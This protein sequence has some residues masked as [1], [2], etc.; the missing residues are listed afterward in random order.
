MSILNLGLYGVAMERP[1][2]KE[3]QYPGMEHLFVSC[4]STGDIRAA[5][6]RFP[7]L[8]HGLDNALQPL[9][10]ML[11]ERFEQLDLKG[12][13]FQRGHKATRTEADAFFNEIKVTPMQ[14]QP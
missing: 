2:I 11:Y 12:I 9:Y 3:D 14:H 5:G 13:P 8:V 1:R 6:K 4:K 7:R 10:N